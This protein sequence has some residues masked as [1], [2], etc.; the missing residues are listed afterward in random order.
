MKP[1]ESMDAASNRDV[2][3]RALDD[4]Y[5]VHDT[6]YETDEIV[7]YRARP[8]G[9]DFRDFAAVLPGVSGGPDVTVRVLKRDLRNQLGRTPGNVLATLRHVMKEANPG[10]AILRAANVKNVVEATDA[11]VYC[12]TPVGTR[13]RERFS[14]RPRTLEEVVDR[15]RIV[16]LAARAVVASRRAN[17][18]GADLRLPDG[19]L[20]RPRDASTDALE[21]RRRSERREADDRVTVERRVESE[22]RE[23]DK[24][25]LTDALIH[26]AVRMAAEGERHM[27]EVETDVAQL[28]SL[29]HMALG[30]E[31]ASIPRSLQTIIEHTRGSSAYGSVPAFATAV[32]HRVIELNR[33]NEVFGHRY[34]IL[35]CV[36]ETTMFAAYEVRDRG[37]DKWSLPRKAKSEEEPRLLLKVLRERDG[38][39]DSTASSDSGEGFGVQHGRIFSVTPFADDEAASSR[40]VPHPQTVREVAGRLRG[41]RRIAD[42]VDELPLLETLA[43]VV[44]TDRTDLSLRTVWFEGLVESLR[45]ASARSGSG[46]TTHANEESPADRL[47]RDDNW[48]WMRWA[49]TELSPPDGFRAMLDYVTVLVDLARVY[50]KLEQLRRTK[51]AVVFKADASPDVPTAPD[52]DRYSQVADVWAVTVL[53]PKLQ[54]RLGNE[55]RRK[56]FTKELKWAGNLIGNGVLGNL[57]PLHEVESDLDKKSKVESLVHYRSPF[58]R[59]TRADHHFKN[60]PASL[61]EIEERL[62]AVRQVAATLQAARRWSVTGLDVWWSNVLLGDEPHRTPTESRSTV[63]SGVAEVRVLVLSDA[64]IDG[65]A[66]EATRDAEDGATRPELR[67]FDTGLLNHMLVSVVTEHGFEPPTDPSSDAEVVD[68]YARQG[69]LPTEPSDANAH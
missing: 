34:E 32:S 59:G 51:W 16:N 37:S 45:R 53:Q 66:R 17:V 10:L 6:L 27:D 29:L 68:A 48:D 64:L 8:S 26:Q 12:V 25:L 4:E 46:S 19:D 21:D 40:F 65:A 5:R 39:G 69:L 60:P 47:D 20:Y 28:G 42:D 23:K 63:A 18:V 11:I 15:L 44:L 3:Q 67:R 43:S 58:A 62:L 24:V 22:R 13:L 56:R 36:N 41:L 14:D 49:T 38:N 2:V 57:Q 55:E 50:R 7:A 61:S 30:G 9:L 35:P 31:N 1:A 54:K 33:L 52:T